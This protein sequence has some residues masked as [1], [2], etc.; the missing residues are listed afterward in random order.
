MNNHHLVYPI[1]LL[2]E[3][4]THTHTLR[5]IIII[6]F[7]RLLFSNLFWLRPWRINTD[8][9]WPLCVSAAMLRLANGPAFLAGLHSD[10]YKAHAFQHAGDV[11]GD[12]I[13]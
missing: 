8:T 9:K 10:P 2:N 5:D 1:H 3:S 4:Y 6:V 11:S 7:Y 12:V 13:S